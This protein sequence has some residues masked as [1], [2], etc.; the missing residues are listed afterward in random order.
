MAQYQYN[1]HLYHVT[2]S[3][4]D[5]IYSPGERVAWSGIYR[6]MGCGREIVH[7]TGHPLPP[8]NHHQHTYGQGSIRWR[9][10][11]TDSPDPS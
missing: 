2:H 11:V 10:N 7:T 4:F 9:L 3:E 1:T 5:K 8:Q 6:C